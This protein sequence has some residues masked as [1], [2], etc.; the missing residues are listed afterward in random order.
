MVKQVAVSLLV[1]GLPYCFPDLSPSVLARAE[2]VQVK[3]VDDA[4]VVVPGQVIVTQDGNGGY[5]TI[6][7]GEGQHGAVFM[8]RAAGEAG[9]RG[10]LGVSVDEVP[11]ALAAQMEV[12]G[13]VMIV[14]VMK[15]SP[16]DQA[17]LEVHDIVLS[18]DGQSIDG[19]SPRIVELIG[20]RKPGDKVNLVVMRQGQKKN[21]TVELGSRPGSDQM[22][23][24]F[25]TAPQTKVEERIRTRGKVM[26]KGPGG[27]WIIKDLG[28][29]DK[30]KDLGD[31]LKL[32]VPHSGS[33]S[34]Q[35]FVDGNR[36][37]VRIQVRD[38]GSTLNINQEDDGEI[39]VT[40]T[41]DNGKEST[42]TYANEEELKAGDPEAY[43]LFS[44]TGKGAFVHL[45]IDAL[46]QHGDIKVDLG[47]WQAKLEEG[48]EEAEEAME[49]ARE[50]IERQYGDMA[51]KF[52]GF[53]FRIGD[54]RSDHGPGMFVM[55][56]VNQSFKVL[57]NGTIE[58]VLRKGDTEVVRT[59][60][61]EA[62]LAKRDPKLYEK[63]QSVMSAEEE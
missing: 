27:Q 30:L 26:G 58:A 17:G 32:M 21:L 10:W 23:W 12:A 57:P 47:E 59:F 13:G 62:D 39:T 34:T 29:L 19:E 61:N 25:D 63:F 37:N 20:S 7:P 8:A 56:R 9:T 2:L 18:V 45:N 49:K 5:W 55:G 33:Q 14:N 15:D 44:G 11:E 48:L 31:H 46:G 42:A 22:V 53:N 41:D 51:E 36:H 38:D 35:V 3:P 28:E 43:E 52:K 50:E 6:A 1:L 40:R 60:T 54:G 4:P 24:K 16:A